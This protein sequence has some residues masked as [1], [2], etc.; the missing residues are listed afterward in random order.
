MLALYR[1]VRRFFLTPFSQ[2]KVLFQPNKSSF[3]VKQI[4]FFCETIFF[5]QPNKKSYIN[6]ITLLYHWNNFAI[7]MK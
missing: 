6:E 2:T 5:F 4:P 1:E 7:S 3:S